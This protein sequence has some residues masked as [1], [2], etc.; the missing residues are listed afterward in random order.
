M[1]NRRDVILGAAATG[2]AALLGASLPASA[3]ASRKSEPKL[4]PV[5]F[6]V[7]EGAC[8]CHVH[9]VGDPKRFPMSQARSYT[10]AAAAVSGLRAVHRALHIARTVVAQ[11]SIYGTDNSCVLDAIKQLGAN[12]RGVAMIDDK[13][14]ESELDAMHKAGVRG[15]RLIFFQT[16]LE[17]PA[18]LADLRQRFQDTVERLKKRNWLIQVYA[19]PAVIDGLGEQIMAAPVPV[20]L[21]HFAG[22]E[23]SLGV[24]QPGFDGVLK[25]VKAG[26]AYVKISAAY[27]TSTQVPDFPDVAPFAKA[28]IAANPQRI[29][30]ASDWPHVDSVPVPGRKPTDVVP[31]L[32]ID[33]GH[34]FNLLPSWAPDA[35]MRKTIL[36]ENPARLYGF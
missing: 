30:W 26:K 3:K 13:T 2:A 10:P 5:N 27:R 34:I 6:A 24:S 31:P 36:V 7:P 18:N 29:L 1:P 35:A 22:A 19:R 17:V 20:V 8:D 12:A 9:I 15:V 4:T 32:P 28:L 33:D 11:I 16:S 25:L 23:A 14:S 21:D